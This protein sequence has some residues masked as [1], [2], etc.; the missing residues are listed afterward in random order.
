MLHPFVHPRRIQQILLEL[1]DNTCGSL[2][3]C[4]VLEYMK[5]KYNPEQIKKDARD[6]DATPDYQMAGS[7]LISVALAI[8]KHEN[9]YVE[10]HSTKSIQDYQNLV[11][12]N[13]RPILVELLTLKNVSFNPTISID[14]LLKQITPITI[15]ILAFY[16]NGNLSNPHFSPLI[17]KT[18]GTYLCFPVW[19]TDQRNDV[20]I[21]ES[22]FENNCWIEKNCLIIKKI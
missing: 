18:N 13:E 3:A 22:E 5:I 15:P 8:A 10:I 17:G 6:G 4:V 16:R 21:E 20:Y 14:D 9:I 11:D 2:S 7:N 19:E 1:G 12:D